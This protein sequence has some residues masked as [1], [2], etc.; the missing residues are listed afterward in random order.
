MATQSWL[1]RVSVIVEQAEELA[2]HAGPGWRT[3]DELQEV[4][5]AALTQFLARRPDIRV[6]WESMTSIPLDDNPGVGRCAV[7]NR[8]VV[9]VENRNE[10]SPSLL[11]RGAVVDGQLLCDEDLPKDHPIAF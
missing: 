2:A 7:C 4:I 8:W 6:E 5:T 11:C 3:D 10:F 1:L 9:D